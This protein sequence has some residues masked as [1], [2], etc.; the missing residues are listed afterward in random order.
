MKNFLLGTLFVFLGIPIFQFC[1]ARIEDA[2]QLLS[3]QNAKKIYQIK[4][5]IEQQQG[6]QEGNCQIG[7]HTQ[8]IGQQI[9]S[10]SQFED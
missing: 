2:S 6:E 3:Y 7:F 5:Q 8:C 10:E 4:K 9:E 1:S